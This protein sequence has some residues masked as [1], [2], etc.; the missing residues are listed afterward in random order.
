MLPRPQMEGEDLFEEEASSFDRKILLETYGGAVHFRRN[1]KKYHLKI[2]PIRYGILNGSTKL[3]YNLKTKIYE[4]YDIKGDPFETRNI[5]L[6]L[7]PQVKGMKQALMN[8]I[9]QLSKYIKL[10]RLYHLNKTSLS[11]EDMERLKSL[12]Y[13]E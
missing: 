8:K 11:E 10:N 13:F 12:G 3:I 5:F 4:V 6:P 7:S 1:S 2:K 9:N